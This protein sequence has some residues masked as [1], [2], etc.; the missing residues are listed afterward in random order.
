MS[1]KTFLLSRDFFKNL[2]FAVIIAAAFILIILIWLSIF[3]RHGQAR[4]VPDFYG[5]S[6]EDAQD[7]AKKRKVRISIIDSV[8]TDLVPRGAIVEQN[9]GAGFKVKKHRRVILTINAFNAEMVQMPNLVGLSARQAYSL[10]ESAGLVPGNPIY[11]PDL[12]IDFVL[13]QL[14]M[15]QQVVPGDSL[16]KGSEIILVLGKGLSSR[17][18]PVPNLIG[19]KLYEAKNNILGSSLTLGTFNFDQSVKTGEDSLNAF[20][21]KQNPDFSEEAT[22]Q[23]GSAVLIW[24]TTDSTRLPVDS[25]LINLSDT[26]SLTPLTTSDIL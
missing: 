22:L 3:T 13:E 20:V 25:T 12:T 11:R 18:T 10:I 9:P 26:L 14:Y 2:G 23:L 1:L 24:L 8:Y 4:P 7:I 5:L 19:K 17:T 6:I 15:G 16:E 21:Y